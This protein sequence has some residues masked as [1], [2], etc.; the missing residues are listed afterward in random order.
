MNQLEK[1]MNA[2]IS[3]GIH[4][5]KDNTKVI[6][7]P[8]CRDYADVYLNDNRIA[9]VLTG[10][11]LTTSVRVNVDMLRRYPTRT[12]ISRLRALGVD[13]CIHKGEVLLDGEPI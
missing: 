12:R 5:S 6:R 7:D 13:V 11:W 1:E 3:K 4:W 9:T 2:A 8:A 10:N